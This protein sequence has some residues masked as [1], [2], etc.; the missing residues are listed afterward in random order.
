M[1]LVTN[2]NNP[3]SVR[4]GTYVGALVEVEFLS[5]PE[6][7][8]RLIMR[9]DAFDVIARGLERGILAYYAP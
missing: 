2:G 5:N 7:V 6:V 8:E 3:M 4:Q 9:P 1:R